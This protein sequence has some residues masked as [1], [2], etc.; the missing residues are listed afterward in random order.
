MSQDTIRTALASVLADL[1]AA[2]AA[3][4]LERPRDPA[5]GDLASNVAMGGA[6]RLGRQPRQGAEEIA[7]RL[8]L[9]AAGVSAVEVAGPGFLNF[10]LTSGAVA[11]VL[12]RILAEDAAFGRPCAG[13]GRKVMVEFVSA[14]P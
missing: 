2:G 14:N 6:K 1:G 13:A 5:H 12:D 11:A 7:A 10:R 3:I 9:G 8:D 4:Q